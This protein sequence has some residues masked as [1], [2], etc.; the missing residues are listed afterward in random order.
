MDIKQI[1]SIEGISANK[2][3]LAALK[4]SVELA[5]SVMASLPVAGSGGVYR[6]AVLSAIHTVNSLLAA[7]S[8]QC[9][10]GAPPADIDMVQDSSGNLIYRCQHAKPHQWTLAGSP[11]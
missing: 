8:A 5:S 4:T 7:S 3:L 10:L 1:S 6:I 9:T 11:I 2:P